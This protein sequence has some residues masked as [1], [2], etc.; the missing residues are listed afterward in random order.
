MKRNGLVGHSTGLMRREAEVQILFSLFLASGNR[1]KQSQEMGKPCNGPFSVFI[2][3]ES[4]RLQSQII[5]MRDELQVIL[6]KSLYKQ[7]PSHT[8]G[9][10]MVLRQYKDQY[11]KIIKKGLRRPCGNLNSEWN[12][13]HDFSTGRVNGV[14]DN[15]DGLCIYTSTSIF[16]ANW[17]QV[18][19]ELGAGTNMEVAGAPW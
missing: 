7:M 13:I 2:N 15:R 9:S 4:C 6:V 8:Q 18:A 14:T 11:G 19:M 12:L 16:N 3:K 17:P 10:Y 5:S 1:L